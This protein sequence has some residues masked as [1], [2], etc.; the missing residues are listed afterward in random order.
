VTLL[1]SLISL[2]IVGAALGR[3]LRNRKRV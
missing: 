3:Y 1:F 2:A